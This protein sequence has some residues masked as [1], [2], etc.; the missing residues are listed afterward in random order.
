MNDV[1]KKPL[2]ANTIPHRIFRPPFG[3]TERY[4]SRALDAGGVIETSDGSVTAQYSALDT[5]WV[6]RNESNETLLFWV[7]RMLQLTEQEYHALTAQSITPEAKKLYDKIS[8]ALALAHRVSANTFL[9][10]L[11]HLPDKIA[12]RD[13]LIAL[14]RQTSRFQE[15]VR[16]APLS[17]DTC[18]LLGLAVAANE[19][20]SRDA[21]AYEAEG[22]YIQNTLFNGVNLLGEKLLEKRKKKNYLRQK[23]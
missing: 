12:T 8:D 13:K 11:N 15:D 14:L 6:P 17:I 7:S 18:Y 5:F 4:A 10:E 9:Y 16:K 3:V 22:A 21:S 19:A 23:A 20:L 2:G 1:I